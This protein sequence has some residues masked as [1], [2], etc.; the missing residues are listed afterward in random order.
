MKPLNCDA[1]NKLIAQVVFPVGAA[2]LLA[3]CAVGPDY[4]KPVVNAPAEFLDYGPDAVL[5]AGFPGTRAALSGGTTMIVDFCIP[6]PGESM[7]AAYQAETARVAWTGGRAEA[8]SMGEGLAVAGDPQ[9]N[10]G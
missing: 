5:M 1:M 8:I 10:G 7:L 2:L 6:A 9:A 4:K 3:G